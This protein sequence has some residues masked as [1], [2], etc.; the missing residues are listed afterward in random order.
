MRNVTPAWSTAVQ[1]DA[2]RRGVSAAYAPV[3]LV[4]FVTLERYFATR[5]HTTSAHTYEYELARL[6]GGG[7]SRCSSIWT[8][9]PMRS[10]CPA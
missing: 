9:C 6:D 7:L 8:K 5:R 1:R 4:D 3:V 10:A 2:T